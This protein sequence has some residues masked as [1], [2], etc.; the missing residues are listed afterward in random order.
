MSNIHDEEK[1]KRVEKVEKIWKGLASHGQSFHSGEARD[2]A[3]KGFG[4]IQGMAGHKYII[5][6]LP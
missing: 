2:A 4:S 1:S 3:I 5:P 6:H